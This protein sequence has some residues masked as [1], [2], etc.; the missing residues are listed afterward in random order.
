MEL[1]IL[2]GPALRA[3]EAEESAW[4]ARVAHEKK[5]RGLR[6]PSFIPLRGLCL[7][8]SYTMMRPRCNRFLTWEEVT[9]DA[10]NRTGWYQLDRHKNVNKGIKARGPL[11][12]ELVDYLASIR[13]L[14]ASGP[15]HFNPSTG[16]PYVD[17]RKQW[18]RFLEIAGRML[19]GDLE[20]KKGKFFNFR[21][22]GASHI[23][24]RGKTPAHLIAVVKMMG[25][26]SVETVNKHHFN[27]ELDLMQEMVLG[28]ERPDVPIPTWGS[29]TVFAVEQLPICDAPLARASQHSR[30]GSPS[31]ATRPEAGRYAHAREVREATKAGEQLCRHV[32]FPL[33]TATR[34]SPSATPRGRSSAGARRR[35]GIRR[36]CCRSTVIRPA[37]RI[38]IV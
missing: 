21:H 11:A 25:D 38:C 27:I 23:A 3:C 37:G 9:L 20:G 35:G 14:N 1:G 13:P 19:G 36:C 33:F 29:L 30:A 10:A 2:M 15:I 34:R 18:N 31:P 32:S 22:T 26:T 17:I 4:N 5:N 24:Q 12:A 28:W 8:G 6:S 16:R 7:I